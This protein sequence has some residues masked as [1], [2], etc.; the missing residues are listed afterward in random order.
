VAE[1]SGSRLP[2]TVWVLGLVSLLTDISSEMVSGLLPVFLMTAMGASASLVGLIEGLAGA[3]SMV[4]KVFSGSFSDYLGRRKP[5]VIAGYTLSA[6]AK[7]L[8]ALAPSVGWIVFA[9]LLDRAGKGVRDAPRD[10]LIADITNLNARGAAFGLRQSLDTVGAFMGPLLAMALMV[11]WAN[12]YRAVFWVACVPAILSLA[13]LFWGVHEPKRTAEQGAP[14]QI[15]FA[16]LRLMGTSFWWLVAIGSVF[17]LARFSE[18]FLVL[19]AQHD[20]LPLAL[21]PLVLITMNLVYASLAYPFG[22]WSDQISGVRL[23][24]ASLVVLALAHALLARGNA[25]VWPGI[26]LWGLHMAMSQGLLSSMVASAAPPALRGTAYGIFNLASGVTM[27]VGS[28]LAGQLWDRLGA[29]APFVAGTIWCG[30]AL[31]LLALHHWS[32]KPPDPANSQ[33]HPPSHRQR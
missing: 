23:L 32:L 2:P 18:A 19:R 28:I 24:A 17:I 21:T 12:D 30:L 29:H 13:L 11:L 31:A 27:L 3:T 7:P 15:A 20:G 14:P 5:L 26:A 25:W 8:L 9:R 6:L 33:R 16:T 10:A 22:K 4:V 1:P